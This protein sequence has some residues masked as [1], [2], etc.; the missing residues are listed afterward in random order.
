[1]VLYYERGIVADYGGLGDGVVERI[2][3]A[4]PQVRRVEVFWFCGSAVW[5][6]EVLVV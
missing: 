5:L 2:G 3:S 1:V 4:P 6:P